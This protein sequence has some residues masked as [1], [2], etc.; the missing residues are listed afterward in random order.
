MRR[1]GSAAT[2]AGRGAAIGLFLA[3]LLALSPVC[4]LA[5]GA[6]V[7]SAD[8]PGL[9]PYVPNIVG[10]EDFVYVW[11]LGVDGLGDGSDKLVTIGANPD[12]AH[13]GEVVAAAS[14]G[15]R[16]GAHHG[17]FTDDR[18]QLWVGGVDDS[19]IFV[20]DVASDPANPEL[21]HT[22]RDFPERSGGVAGP[23]A[24]QALPGRML[25]AGLSNTRD[26]GARSGLVE[27][28]NGAEF[29]KTTWMPA[30]AQQGGDLRLLPRLNRM[31]SGSFTGRRTYSRDVRELLASPSLGQDFGETVTVW[32]LRVRKP[33]Q[34]LEV[35][36]APVEL[37][38]ALRPR[39]E[40][41]FAVTALDARL[42][43]IFLKRDG[44]FEAEP[45]ARVGD[46]EARPVPV[47]MSLS[48]NDRFLFVASFRDGTV[49]VFDV[50]DPRDP[51]LVLTRKI[52]SQLGTVAQSFDGR[53][54]YFSSSFLPN[55]DGRGE[56]EEQYLRAFAFDDEELE[57]R[58][59]VDFAERGL[60]NP[61]GLYFGSV[62]FYQGRV[63]SRGTP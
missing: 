42:W 10:Q 15:G 61:H 33:L 47:S 32:D 17:G 25:I 24:F 62:S 9:S 8:E 7:A 36:G 11:T 56:S 29:V 26:G 39:H 53:R 27:Y 37:R 31:L 20:F 57:P 38:W 19:R 2:G 30:S 34:I 16:H 44:S 43:G 51:D 14:V 46:P 5:W 49:R 45:L 1:R 12:A 18:R 54:V 52:G 63:A 55:W 58:F 6:A 59:E 48:S 50:S 41:A 35:P 23:Y 13:Y 60:G 22:I 28:T 3:R 21:I 40:Y 4:C